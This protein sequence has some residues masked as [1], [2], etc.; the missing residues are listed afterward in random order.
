MAVCP[1]CGAVYVS[2]DESCA[3]CFD[4]LLALDHSRAE[5]WGRRHALAFSA[6]ALQH[7]DR[8]ARN[9]LERAWLL[10]Y[11]VY[12][13]GISADRVV[14]GLRRSGKNRPDW[15]AP[16][17]PS[18]TPAP[19]FAVTIADLGS[20]AAETYPEQLDSWCR[21]TLA[22]WRAVDVV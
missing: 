19:S 9:V 11:S 18:G 13:K 5:P 10:L 1:G 14:E 8:F 6:Y 17:L 3:A 21:A 7:P 22:G 15:A 2:A 20:F 12:V 16:P 4:E